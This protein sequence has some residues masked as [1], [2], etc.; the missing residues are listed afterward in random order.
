MLASIL[1]IGI[2]GQ[3]GAMIKVRRA[4][5]PSGYDLGFV[6]E[7]IAVDAAPPRASRSRIF[8]GRFPDRSRRTRPT[9]VQRE[10]GHGR[11]CDCGS[12]ECRRLD[13]TDKCRSRPTRSKRSGQGRRR[14]QY[15]G[16]TAI[17]ELRFVR[18][19]N[20][21]EDACC[22]RR[23]CGRRRARMSAAQSPARSELDW[24][25]T[26]RLSASLSAPCVPSTL[27]N[28]LCSSFR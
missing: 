15:S 20:A 16:R 2:S 8:A 21:S 10:C 28:G 18:E 11:R 12:R 3:D 23:G 19:R 1:A 13:R 4:F 26:Q 5:S 7:I 25:G 6:G 24:Q 9:C 22:D 27:Y 17:R 14:I